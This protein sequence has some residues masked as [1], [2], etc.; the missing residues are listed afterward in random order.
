MI[1]VNL[2]ACNVRSEKK[3]NTNDLSEVRAI[4][5]VYDEKSLLKQVNEFSNTI[6]YTTEKNA[7]E[8]K[9]IDV[10][11]KKWNLTYVNTM[12]YPI[13][14]NK[15]HNYQI[16]DNK[17][18]YLLLKE[19]GSIYA[20]LGVPITTLDISQNDT[21]EE[22]RA[23]FE[24]AMS[25]LIDFLKYEHCKVEQTS[26]GAYSILY[27]NLFQ[28]YYSTMLSVYISN[29]GE[30][31]GLVIRDMVDLSEADFNID[32]EHENEMI[33]SKIKD[34]LNDDWEY[35]DHEVSSYPRIVSYEGEL[36]VYY[37]IQ[38]HAYSKAS[39]GSFGF[40]C[41]IIIPIR[42]LINNF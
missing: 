10:L 30:V 25:G 31:S 23:T 5:E 17:E 6:V 14:E 11:N 4:T 21:P 13:G 8:T 33:L 22:I 40:A 29:N 12:F 15:L 32:K 38:G 20:I 34:M 2:N 16:G 19:D 35:L 41:R 3:P 26:Y 36:C 37:S 24:S 27:F 39:D 42:L 1:I 18:S 9:T 7:G 28:D